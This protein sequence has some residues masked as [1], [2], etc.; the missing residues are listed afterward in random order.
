MIGIAYNK[1]TGIVGFI[2]HDVVRHTE[3]DII[4]I[5]GALIGCSRDHNDFIF[6]DKLPVVRVDRMKS[7]EPTDVL[8]AIGD[9]LPDGL[10]DI[11]DQLPENLEQKAA[12]LEAELAAAKV[13][14]ADLRARDALL[15]DDV[16]MIYEI[17]AENGLI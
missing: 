6:V 1:E 3:T 11:R 2:V 17:M 9:Q 15:Q 13:E 16:L 7:G 12:R 10:V 4:G 5:D 8:L 14:N